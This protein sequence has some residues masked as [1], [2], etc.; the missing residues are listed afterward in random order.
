[1][2]SRALKGQNSK[3]LL[4]VQRS[5][6]QEDTVHKGLSDVILF[7]IG[8]IASR[9]N[10]WTVIHKL[11]NLIHRKVACSESEHTWL[12]RAMHCTSTHSS[13]HHVLLK[14]VYIYNI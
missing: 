13:T 4:D 6:A 8:T 7:G 9:R 14:S 11:C 5:D 10:L 12:N 3:T 1:M 2:L